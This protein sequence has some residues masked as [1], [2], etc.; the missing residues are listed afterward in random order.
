MAHGPSCSEA[1]GNLPRPGLEPV[2]PALAGGFLTAAPP[3]KSR[4]AAFLLQVVAWL[5]EKLSGK[6]LLRK[7]SLGWGV[8][9]CEIGRAHV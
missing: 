6:L 8:C 2:F 9:V 5:A 4:G 7:R 1:C 3:G